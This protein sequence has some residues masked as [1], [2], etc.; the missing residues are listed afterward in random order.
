M[1]T[2]KIIIITAIAVTLLYSCS[3]DRDEDAR[4][5]AIEHVK[6][7]NPEFK[8]NQYGGASIEN[9]ESPVKSDSTRIFESSGTVPPIIPGSE[10]GGDPKDV[11]NPPRR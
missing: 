1:K 10:D 2:T 9:I 4:K 7:S 6:N 11:P 3:N 8:L 5:D